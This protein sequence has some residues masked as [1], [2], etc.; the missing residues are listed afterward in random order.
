MERSDIYLFLRKIPV[1]LLLYM[2]AKTGSD[3]VKKAISL[4]FTQLQDVRPFITGDDLIEMGVLPGPRLKEIL[5]AVLKARLNNQV[6]SR[7]E[8]LRLAENLVNG[9]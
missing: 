2:M 1:E 3:K 9:R 4:Y 6:R 5:D 8:E 7:E